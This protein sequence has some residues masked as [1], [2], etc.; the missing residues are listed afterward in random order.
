MKKF[1]VLYKGPATPMEQMTEEQSKAANDGWSKWMEAHQGDIVDI[2]LP[3]ANGKAIVD[4]GSTGTP[5]DLNG[6]TIVQA[7]DMDG[8]LKIVEG[9]P[10]LSEGKGKFSLEVYELMPMPEM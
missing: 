9:H 10:F 5:D 4:D 6:Y 8:A 2:G 7:D 1:I 3:M